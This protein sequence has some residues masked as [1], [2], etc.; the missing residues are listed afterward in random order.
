MLAGRPPRYWA[1]QDPTGRTRRKDGRMLS[2]LGE[3]RLQLVSETDIDILHINIAA[4]AAA[5]LHIYTQFYTNTVITG[6]WHA[7]SVLLVVVVKVVVVELVLVIA[8]DAAVVMLPP[9]HTL[10]PTSVYWSGAVLLLLLWP[11]DWADTD[12][13][14]LSLCWAGDGQHSLIRN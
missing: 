9:I 13:L 4:A 2:W 7:Q 14:G 5:L 11:W 1:S 8:W 12:Q 6:G 3:L 10:L